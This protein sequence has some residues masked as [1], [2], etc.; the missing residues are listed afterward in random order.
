VAASTSLG[1]S[2]RGHAWRAIAVS[3]WIL[4]GAAALVK[5]QAQ[6]QVA[7]GPLSKAHAALEGACLKCHDTPGQP[8]NPAK[9][10]GCHDRAQTN[11]KHAGR[12]GYRYDSV[13]CY[14]YHPR[15]ST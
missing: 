1:S 13:G 2:H 10:L 8:V 14:S 3:A 5:T 7:P 15:G 11:A 6:V 9:C 4:V 12:A